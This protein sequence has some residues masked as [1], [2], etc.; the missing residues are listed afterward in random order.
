M[1][2]PR[3]LLVHPTFAK[4]HASSDDGDQNR[5]EA[6]GKEFKGCTEML[7]EVGTSRTSNPSLSLFST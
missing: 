4:I 3:S 5:S 1:V 6:C 2:L 7:D